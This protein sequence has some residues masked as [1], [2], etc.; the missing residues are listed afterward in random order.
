ME[1]RWLAVSD[2]LLV[3]LDCSSSGHPQVGRFTW[4]GT[5]WVLV[6]VSRQRP[7]ASAPKE[8]GGKYQGSFAIADAYSGCPSCGASQFV[9]CG[10]CAR[11]ACWDPSWATYLC[12][13]CGDSGQVDRTIDA[14]STTLGP[15]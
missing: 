1:G 13:H 9:Q 8:T 15:G 2:V 12:P 11:L 7:G 10:R 3:S 14:I 6:G 5:T 4:D